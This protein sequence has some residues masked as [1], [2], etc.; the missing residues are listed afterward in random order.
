MSSTQLSEGATRQVAPS[1]ADTSS[2][3]YVIV[4]R[5]LAAPGTILKVI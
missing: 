2:D 4:Q 1:V 5:Q 3:A